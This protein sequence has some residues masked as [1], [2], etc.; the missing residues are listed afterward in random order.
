MLFAPS[1]NLNNGIV[2]LVAEADVPPAMSI[3]AYNAS[4]ATVS[5]TADIRVDWAVD[6]SRSANGIFG[7]TAA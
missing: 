2:Y 6:I 4:N 5:A 1:D 7:K 3:R